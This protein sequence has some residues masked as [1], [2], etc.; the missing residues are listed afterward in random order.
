MARLMVSELKRRF[1]KY[2][3]SGDEHHNS[4]FLMATALDPR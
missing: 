3:D 2:I 4:L 1:K